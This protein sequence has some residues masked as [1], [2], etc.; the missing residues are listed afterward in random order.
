MASIQKDILEQ[1]LLFLQKDGIPK[2]LIKEIRKKLENE[3]LNEFQLEYF[4]NKVY[5]SYFNAK[6]ENSESVGTITAQSIGEPGTQM[7]LRTFHHAGMEEFS[8][9]AGLPR[10][11][12]LVD[13]RRVP[14]TPQTTIYLNQDYQLNEE[15]AIEVLHQVEQVTIDQIAKDIHLDYYNWQLNVILDPILCQRRGIT[16]DQVLEVFKTNIKEV[17]IE[18]DGNSIL[19]E[20]K[21][22]N[23]KNLLKLREKLLKKVIKGIK[24]IKRGGIIKD[25]TTK[26]WFIKTEGTNLKAI[27]NIEGIDPTKTIS[28]NIKEIEEVYGIEAAR[29]MLIKEIMQVM[30][31]QDITIDLRHV[32]LLADS[33]CS[34]GTLKSIGRYGISG[35]KSSIFAKAAF[36]EPSKHL[37]NAGIYGKTEYINGITETIIVGHVCPI[38]TG[39]IKLEYDIDAGLKVLKKKVKNS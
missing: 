26:T 17:E 2:D 33:M 14:L 21:V 31:K 32:L 35:A 25:D 3:E 28:N 38:G 34:T 22:E 36:E 15:K 6:I 37:L 1:K 23:V 11:G 8:V 27:L 24:G 9:S 19:L 4:L 30:T 18:R 16:I 39:R 5:V 12:E 13:L 10:L 29:S 7:T 20:T